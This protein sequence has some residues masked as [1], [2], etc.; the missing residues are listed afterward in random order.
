MLC[1]SSGAPFLLDVSV[2]NC[3][4]FQPRLE[5]S[6]RRVRLEGHRLQR[7]EMGLL[8]STVPGAD[9]KLYGGQAVL[10]RLWIR[11]GQIRRA[12]GACRSD[13][14]YVYISTE[15]FWFKLV[16]AKHQEHAAWLG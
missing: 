2:V 9:S 8:L 3:A 11:R 15:C 13:G 12:W 4:S 5:L 10:P 6:E 1:L 7:A 14:F 16:F